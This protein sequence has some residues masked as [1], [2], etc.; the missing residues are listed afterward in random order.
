[1]DTLELMPDS[2]KIY[3]DPVLARIIEILQEQHEITEEED[4]ERRIEAAR[5][6][7]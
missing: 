5:S 2:T 1:M 3:G 7:A 4:L 6:I